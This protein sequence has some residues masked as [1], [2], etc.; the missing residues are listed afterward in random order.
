MADLMKVALLI[1]LLYYIASALFTFYLLF[2]E[3]G[4]IDNERL[5]SRIRRKTL[6]EK[7]FLDFLQ[8]SLADDEQA[9]L[10]QH[11]DSVKW[12]EMHE[13][14]KKQ[15]ILG[16]YF[17]GIMKLDAK[18]KA[19][20]DKQKSHEIFKGNKPT[21]QELGKW[22]LTQQ[23]ITKSNDKLFHWCGK[24]YQKFSQQG[25]ECYI[26][27]GQ[28]NNYYYPDLY[29]RIPGDIDVVINSNR[30]TILKYCKKSIKKYDI[31]YRHIEFHKD[32]I[33]IEVHFFPVHMN[34][35]FN[36]R[37][38]QRWFKEHIQEQCHHLVELPHHYGKMPIPTVEFSLISQL[39]H[40]LQHELTDGV[41]LRQVI[42]YYYLVKAFHRQDK[43]TDFNYTTLT[44]EFGLYRFAQ[45][46][47]WILREILGI[48]EE[49]LLVPPDDLAGSI[50]WNDIMD[51]GNFGKYYQDDSIIEER[52]PL[53]RFFLIIKRNNR[54]MKLYPSE[55]LWVPL[56]RIWHFT[57]Q[58]FNR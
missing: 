22:M 26:L 23:N 43:E 50:L 33:I 20:Q 36:D 53:K 2:K 28:G 49:K 5:I 32:G 8:Y 52:S 44:K 47:M 58:L 45:A 25:L 30:K 57:W 34:N 1:F 38:L 29:E 12:H 6:L 54:Y 4:H 56:I 35:P 14:G 39:G 46:M 13:F 41:G 7:G 21:I 48:E 15:A 24:I 11:I 37:R 10:P 51:G 17:H 19:E 16:I 3:K 55:V 40:V 31:K 18:M 27:K 9:P 42:D